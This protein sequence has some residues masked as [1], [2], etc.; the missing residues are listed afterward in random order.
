LYRGGR[1]AFNAAPARRVLHRA[2][3]RFGGLV[4]QLTGSG[5]LRTVKLWASSRFAP[6]FLHH[7]RSHDRGLARFLRRMEED[8][9]AG[10]AAPA[11]PAPG[12]EAAR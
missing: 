10:A 12:A 11:A 5:P 1:A 8:R 6:W 2:R 4:V 3:A 7:V 9:A